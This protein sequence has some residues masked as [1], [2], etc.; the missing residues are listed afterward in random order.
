[1]RNCGYN[2]SSL[3]SV[4]YKENDSRKWSIV[5]DN[6]C[7]S[8][9]LTCYKN[10]TVNCYDGQRFLNT[11][12]NLTTDSIEVLIEDF[13]KSGIINKHRDYGLVKAETEQ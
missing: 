12:F 10:G 3:D 2:V 1:M 9:I 5:I 11:N 7:A 8:I 4:S 13:N 6:N